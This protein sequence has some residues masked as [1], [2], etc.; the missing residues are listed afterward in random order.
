M[1]SIMFKLVIEP[2]EFCGLE[3]KQV[4]ILTVTIVTNLGSWFVIGQAEN[5]FF[6]SNHKLEITYISTFDITLGLIGL[7]VREL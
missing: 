1:V 7:T 5:C 4:L 3:S 2:N 6:L